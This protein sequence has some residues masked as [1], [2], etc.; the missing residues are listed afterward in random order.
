MNRFV[1]RQRFYKIYPATVVL[2]LINF[3]RNVHVRM[4]NHNN[5][6]LHGGEFYH[7]QLT[8]NAD[9]YIESN[10]RIF[11]VFYGHSQSRVLQHMTIS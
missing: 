10:L 9:G 2:R 7:F 1:F 11:L 3:S 6:Q 4:M 8:L 5:N